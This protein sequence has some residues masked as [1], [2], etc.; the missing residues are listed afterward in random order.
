M[1]LE[2]DY[3]LEE[4]KRLIDGAPGESA[5][6]SVQPDEGFT[7]LD[8][9]EKAKKPTS[10]EPDEKKKPDPELQVTGLPAV[11][12]KPGTQQSKKPPGASTSQ[13]KP[14]PG[15]QISGPPAVQQ[16]PKS[17]GQV[18][19]PPAVR[20]KPGLPQAKQQP[21]IPAVQRKPGTPQPKLPPGAPATQQKRRSPGSSGR[22]LPPA[23][24]ED[25]GRIRSYNISLDGKI[26]KAPDSEP[27]LDM[28]SDKFK[29]NF[30]F[31][32]AY[33]DVP[34]NRPLR[35]RRERRTGCI[36][37]ILYFAFVVCVSLVLASLMWMA[38]V[39]VLGFGADDEA[40]NVTVREGFDIE[41]ITDMLFEAGLIKYKF[42]FS[43]YADYSNAEEK[44]S[45]G[46]YI[47]NK[48]YDYRA[49]VQG[50]TAR[51]GVRVEKTVTIPEGL[52]LAQIF[53]LLE[54]H[55][56]CDAADLWDA[57][58]NHHFNF[59]F[60]DEETVGDRLR[61]EGFLF[62]E[63]Y[64]FYLES[65]PVQV[66][67]RF[68]REFGRRFT[69][70]YIE[71]AEEMGFSIHDI[72]NVAAMIEREAGSDQERP[73]IAAV[74]YNRLASR[75]FPLLQIDATIFYA[76]AGTGIPF[77]TGYDHPFNTYIYPDLPPGPIA[78]PG[79]ASIRAAL[80]PDSTNEFFYA[81]NRQGTHN[82][83]RT[84][85]QHEAFVRSAE[86]GGRP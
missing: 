51:A 46:Q 31:D 29:V 33:R 65:T 14:K 73:R 17:G 54:D 9:P 85:A 80:Y 59:H 69:E 57:A 58:T 27:E 11:R 10:D 72:I 48:S 67:S 20:Q 63:T 42:L 18:S 38:T 26:T 74:I 77:S 39:D 60:L 24:Q 13:Q 50:M 70:D 1:P 3:D 22:A 41:D 71:R 45:A 35:L 15:S 16:K 4:I 6:M 81:L 75:D 82:F 25:V 49:L 12:Q 34:E 30:D 44:I 56:I 32:E 86:Y 68:L 84:R 66:L 78:N 5:S 7:E 21:G 43:M 76:I 64:N 61:L 37:G 62:P 36:G 52:T 83:F 53:T 19:G 28:G 2:P 40:V 79:M 47:L 55:G 23:E 8:E